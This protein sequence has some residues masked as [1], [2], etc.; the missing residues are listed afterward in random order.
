MALASSPHGRKKP[1]NP[2]APLANHG[3]LPADLMFDVLLC[4][5]AKELC[6]FPRPVFA[7]AH[8]SRHPLVLGL[9]NRSKVHIIVTCPATPSRDAVA[10]FNMATEETE[11]SSPT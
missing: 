7:K 10:S 5:P 1:P 6:R 11:A 9:R 3:L 2:A 8:S 4:L